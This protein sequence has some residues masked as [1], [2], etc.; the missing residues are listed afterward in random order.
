LPTGGGVTWGCLEDYSCSLWLAAAS[1]ARTLALS[2]RTGFVFCCVCVCVCVL[3]TKQ[4]QTIVLIA[5]ARG[6]AGVCMCV[7]VCV[8]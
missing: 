4:Q 8:F 2:W 3:L 5:G 7:C 6:A 1:G